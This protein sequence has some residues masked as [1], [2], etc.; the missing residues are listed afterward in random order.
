MF[1]F[2]LTMVSFWLCIP[3]LQY[4]LCWQWIKRACYISY[5]VV[6]LFLC[7]ICLNCLHSSLVFCVRKFRVFFWYSLINLHEPRT[8][9][10]ILTC[11]W[12]QKLPLVF[13]DSDAEDGGM[14]WSG[15][16]AYK[17][18]FFSYF[19]ICFVSLPPPPKHRNEQYI[20]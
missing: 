5:C 13:P 18:L 14:L 1:L 11:I 6:Q 2:F 8:T 3:A 15:V 19:P 16:F 9:H 20:K 12:D 17:W 10:Q 7:R 4:K